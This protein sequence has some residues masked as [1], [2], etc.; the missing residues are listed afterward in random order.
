[1][2]IIKKAKRSEAYLKIGLSGVSGSGKT[3]SALL[4]AKGLVGDLTKVCVLDTENSSSNLYSDLGEYSVL[5]FEPPFNPNRY[6]KAIDIMVK[7]G[8]QCIIIDSA[9]HEWDGAG[10]CL[11]LH[12]Q[13]GGKF[14]DWARVTPLHKAFVDSMLQAKAHVICTMR[15]KTDYGMVE[16]NGRMV[17]EKMGLKEVQRENFEYDLSLNFDINMEHLAIATKDRTGLFA[18]NLPFKITEE[19]G[20]KIQKWNKGE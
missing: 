12:Q 2:S 15:R 20:I 3:Y 9:S 8:F 18:D 14:Q 19:T 7:E 6:I 17:V 16:K 5:P 1:M 10:G 13:F 4:L 11:E